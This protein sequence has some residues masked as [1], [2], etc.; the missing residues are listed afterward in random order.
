MR[1]NNKQGMHWACKERGAKHTKRN[2]SAKV[3]TEPAQI[4]VTVDGAPT[5]VQPAT[6]E[7]FSLLVSELGL[8]HYAEMTLMIDGWVQSLRARVRAA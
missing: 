3:A 6:L 1:S 5:V 2:V 4:M 7:R 8:D